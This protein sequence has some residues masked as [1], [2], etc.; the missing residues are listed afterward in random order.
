M[1]T[2]M[3]DKLII[4]Y[5]KPDHDQSHQPPRVEAH[6]MVNSDIAT[7]YSH[8]KNFR[9]EMPFAGSNVG[10]MR[11]EPPFGDKVKATAT[12]VTENLL[13]EAGYT[14]IEAKSYGVDI[15]HLEGVT[16]VERPNGTK[17]IIAPPLVV[18]IPDEG[19]LIVDGLH[20]ILLAQRLGKSIDVICIDQ[21]KT[22]YK[23][24]GLPVDLNNVAVVN[25]IPKPELRH[26][27]RSGVGRKDL[28]D[29]NFTGTAGPRGNPLVDALL[30]PSVGGDTEKRYRELFNNATSWRKK[31]KAVGLTPN[32][33]KDDHENPGIVPGSLEVNQ[34]NKHVAAVSFDHLL[35]VGRPE[36]ARYLLLAVSQK[37]HHVHDGRAGII[38]KVGDPQLENWINSN[39]K[40]DGE[41][42]LPEEIR[43]RLN[44]RLSELNFPS[45]PPQPNFESLSEDVPHIIDGE[46]FEGNIAYFALVSLASSDSSTISF[47]ENHNS[48]E[49]VGRPSTQGTSYCLIR[50]DG[51]VL[52]VRRHREILGSKENNEEIELPRT[53]ARDHKRV[54]AETGILDID[55]LPISTVVCRQEPS[56]NNIDVE[57]NVVGLPSTSLINKSDEVNT[58]NQT[59][60]ISKPTLVDGEVLDQMVKKG[61][62]T[63]D[64]SLAG[65]TIGQLAKGFLEL[66]PGHEDEV[67]VLRQQY[68]LHQGN[69][70]LTM[71]EV[72][73]NSG[74]LIGSGY[75]DNGKWLNPVHLISPNGRPQNQRLT[76]IPISQIPQMI[77]DGVFDTSTIAQIRRLFTTSDIW[78]Y[79]SQPNVGQ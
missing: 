48:E 40:I 22:E 11:L 29:L 2:E 1:F 70:I 56:R 75:Q 27:Y 43:Q 39:P 5:L 10:R 57:F 49:I 59:L 71:P 46:I 62:M 64:M 44:A 31:R 53:Y 12:Y 45:I 7:D 14:A 24:R 47:A 79:K 51:K 13:D 8:I 35:K 15:F 52:V 25:K 32:I 55:N 23:P 3:I 73:V 78:K 77:L 74:S 67:L 68:S 19:Y 36:K 28:I 34:I 69:Y 41:T 20:R 58:Y 61:E 17:F 4:S 33:A 50:P 42:I 72:S 9:G 16:S 18:Y 37:E 6:V 21:L 76:A 38:F 63:C 66:A 60:E 30:T 65:L 26:N 54:E